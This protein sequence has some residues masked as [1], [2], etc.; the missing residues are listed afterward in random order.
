MFL[1]Q[2][3][4]G[5]AKSQELHLVSHMHDRALSIWIIT[6]CRELGWKCRQ[7]SIPDTDSG[8]DCPKQQLTLLLHYSV[9]LTIFLSHFQALLYVGYDFSHQCMAVSTYQSWII[10]F[11]DT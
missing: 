5:Q 11:I 9:H 1:Q 6:C 10:H 8:C 7:D 3:E 2:S 4:L